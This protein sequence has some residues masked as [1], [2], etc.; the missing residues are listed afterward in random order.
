VSAAPISAVIVNYEGGELLLDCVAALAEESVLETILVDNGSTDGS[1]AT[2]AA[3]Y[4]HLKV[5]APGRNLGFAG[6]ANFG[7]RQARGELLLFLNPDI[8]LRPGSVRALAAYFGD[9]EV[10]VVGPPLQV[11]AAGTVECGATVDVIG[12]P[13]ALTTPSSPL[14]VSG[15]AL[16]TR[17]TL[18]HEFDGFD[19]RLFMFVEDVDYCWRA[20]LRGF[21][22]VVPRIE[23]AWHFGGAATAGGYLTRDG[24]SSTLFRVALRERNTLAV[25]LKCYG[26]PIL[27]IVAPLYVVQSLVT[28]GALAVCGR[29][30]TARAMVAGLR[31]NIRELPRTLKLR[32][33]VQTSRKVG[34]TFILRRMH[35]G[36]WKLHLLLRFGVPTVVEE[37]PTPVEVGE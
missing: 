31:W 7:A 6:G 2:A 1:A 21:D 19:D 30:A 20:L 17:A 5:L 3:E 24:V 10:G 36:I 33:R 35:R 18:F 9:P 28:A 29:S 8:R 11:E 4:P 26:A 37:A 13:V 16:M 15:C 23:P 25:L 34:D 32:R 27:S 22:V 14:Y 12:S